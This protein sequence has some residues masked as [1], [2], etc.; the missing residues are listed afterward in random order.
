MRRSLT[1]SDSISR[2]Q[3]LVLGAATAGG[4]AGCL[5]SD[6]TGQ[7]D[8]TPT[9]DAGSD[10]TATLTETEEGSATPTD[11]VSGGSDSDD[12]TD[13][14]DDDPADGS[15]EGSHGDG[16]D[17]I[18]TDL[19][20]TGEAVPELQVFDELMVQFMTDLDI[21]TGALSIAHEGDVIFQ[22]GYGWGDR[23][24]TMPVDPDA[25]FRI[26]SI[27]KLF[28]M[29]AILRLVD[30]GDL[31]LADRVYPLLDVEPP[32][33]ELAD[34]RIRD[35]TVEH[36]LSHAGGWDRSRHANP[37]YNPL[38]VT[39]TLELDGPPAKEDIVRYML[40]Q[41]LQFEPGT[42]SVYSN[43]GYVLL[44]MVIE[45]VTG[46][47]YQEYLEATLFD[48][49]GI[50][51]IELGRTRPENRHPDEIWYEDD[52]RCPNVFEGDDERSYE[53]ASHGIVLQTFDA[54]GGHIAR[55]HALVRAVAELD[56]LWTGGEA[57][58]SPEVI[59]FAGSHPGS[60]AY[61]ERRGEVTVGVM[62][63]TRDIPLGPY[64]DIQQGVDDAIADVEEWP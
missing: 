40:D 39:E 23:E 64:L 20:I 48:P 30:D 34:E 49:T 27:S 12:S 38:V 42:D 63:N 56:W 3:L 41:P 35:V 5:G 45:S 6:D 29:D 44:G 13:S 28:T 24:R 22:R 59:R 32:G 31:A 21:S 62:V 46:R 36:L 25:F 17:S 4:V 52:E 50:D 7:S 18:D 19:P 15:G 26:G 55:S 43:F 57:Y 8:D 54:A 11:T 9:E 58:R 61:T 33:G 14:D 10:P 60:F 47:S 16:A 53:C 37:L 2:R 51:G 1:E